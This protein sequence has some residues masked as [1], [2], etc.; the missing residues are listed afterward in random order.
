MSVCHSVSVSLYTW[1]TKPGCVPLPNDELGSISPPSRPS[2]PLQSAG[3]VQYTHACVLPHDP[4]GCHILCLDTGA[5][6]SP[7]WV[8]AALPLWHQGWRL[9]IWCRD[10]SLLPLS[11]RVDHHLLPPTGC[12]SLRFT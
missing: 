7:L 3:C 8:R 10:G 4:L 9:A 12:A 5:G 1:T 6:A 2:S 11:R